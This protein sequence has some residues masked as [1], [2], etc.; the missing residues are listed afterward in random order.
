V[1]AIGVVRVLVLAAG[2][3]RGLEAQDVATRLEGRVPTSVAHAVQ[4]IA[5]DAAARGLPVELLIQ[6][7]LEGGAKGVPADRVIAAV[8]VVATQL[9]EARGAL[10]EAGIQAPS[11]QAV[12]GGAYALNAGL[13]AH[14]IRDLGRVSQP[15]Y[16]PALTLR[17]AATL[18]ALGV[19]AQRGLH[20]MTRMMHAGRP[21]NE[22]R[23]LPI[24]VQVGM[25]RGATA[26]EAAEAL[27]I[28][29]DAQGQQGHQGHEGQQGEQDQPRP[30]KP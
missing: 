12:E 15:P 17:V 26:A 4:A 25:A 19:P 23:D 21:A 24:E 22:L 5:Q 29:E 18:T 2:S 1:K 28:G 11:P 7:A 30:R 8:R 6:K 3:A 27:D 16:D 9:D 10:R 14:Q 13:N 20:L